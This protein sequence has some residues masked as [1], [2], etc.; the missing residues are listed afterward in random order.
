MK[1]ILDRTK[2]TINATPSPPPP[3][4]GLHNAL[5][6]IRPAQQ[7]AIPAAPRLALYI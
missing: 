3:Q 4:P 7:P 6:R 2:I 1:E 5:T